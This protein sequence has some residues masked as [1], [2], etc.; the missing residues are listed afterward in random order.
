MSVLASHKVGPS[1]TAIGEPGFCIVLP[2]DACTKTAGLKTDSTSFRLRRFRTETAAGHFDPRW[3]ED[4]KNRT[5]LWAD[6]E[7][8]ARSWRLKA[9]S[10][11]SCN[12]PTLATPSNRTY[13]R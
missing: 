2:T 5:P 3:Q 12:R 11:R 9:P 7:C 6:A 4:M 10:T 13:K 1:V 8:D